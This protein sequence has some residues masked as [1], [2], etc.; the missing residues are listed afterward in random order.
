M[1]EEIAAPVLQARLASSDPPMV[2]DVREDWE[3]E[4]VRLPG[5]LH[6]PMNTVPERLSELP[7][8][9][10]IV[11]MCRSGGRSLKVAQYLQSRGYRVANLTG[12]ILAWAEQVDPQL[13][14]Y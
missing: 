11:V 5:I 2:L 13:P 1:I 12:G 7:Q 9:R 6:V 8:D 14:T 10:Q 4:I 3:L